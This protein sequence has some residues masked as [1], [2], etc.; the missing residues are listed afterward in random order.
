VIRACGLALAAAL[1]AGAA[2]RVPSAAPSATE[3]R[4]E[5]SQPHMGTIVRITLYARDEPAAARASAAAFDRIAQLDAALS[6][7]RDD[8]ELTALSRRAGTGPVAVSADLFRVLAAAQTIARASDG[9]F[10][11]TV[12]PMSVLWR[13]ARRR[14]QLPEGDRMAAARAHVGYTKLELDA[15][16]R[17]AALRVEGMQLDLGGIAKGFAAGEAMRVLESNGIAR[18]LVAAG[19]D[20]VASDAPPGE[21]GWTVAIGTI[22]GAEP[23]APITL[24]RGAVSTSGDAEQFL[25]A[26]G[27]RYSHIFDPR[28]GAAV[29]GR[30][31]VTIRAPDGATSDALATAVSVMGAAAGLALVERTPGAAGFVVEEA[32]QSSR[33]HTSSRWRGEAR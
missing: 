32:G 31:S 27:T 11:V 21:R 16:A 18:A 2:G 20:V 29:T 9:A 3:E 30:R 12:G 14:R 26:G 6:D 1:V 15:A 23:P 13:Q 25:E 10:D 33:I 7:Y 17:T 22:A 24:S 8:S 4:F 28:T 19:G 5:F